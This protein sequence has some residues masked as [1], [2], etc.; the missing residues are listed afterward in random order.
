MAGP[1]V[2]ISTGNSI[3]FGTSAFTS[4][5]RALGWEGVGDLPVHDVSHLGTADPGAGQH[6]NKPKLF[7]KISDP[8]RINME[9]HFDPEN[10]PP[11]DDDPETVT[12][13]FAS[14]A[15]WAGT[16]KIT[17]FSFTGQIDEVMIGTGV[18]EFSGPITRVDTV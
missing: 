6:G 12:L 18:V 8:G 14:G 11:I 15:T 2:A 13:T 3:T 4:E 10:H 1:T 7:G 16:A 17:G 9:F 5:F